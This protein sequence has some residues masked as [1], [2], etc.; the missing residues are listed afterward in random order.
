MSAAYA[1][2]FLMTFLK[3]SS[4]QVLD[5][6]LQILY[7]LSQKDSKQTVSKEGVN[8][9]PVYKDFSYSYLLITFDSAFR[10]CN[11][12]RNVTQMLQIHANTSEIWKCT[13]EVPS[14]VPAG[15]MV[16]INTFSSA[17]RQ[18]RVGFAKQGFWL[19][20]GD[21]IGHALASATRA[22]GSAL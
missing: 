15:A 14:V 8:S 2:P 9:A 3:K 18:G 4:H 21:S 1:K 16:P 19:I 22:Q 10:Y 5:L 17:V 11:L 12:S 20:T 6:Y 13:P 7:P